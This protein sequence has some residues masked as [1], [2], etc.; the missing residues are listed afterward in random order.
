[1]SLFSFLTFSSLI[2]SPP[3]SSRKSQL[4]NRA[5]PIIGPRYVGSRISRS[6][7]FWGNND[8]GS[9][10]AANGAGQEETSSSEGSSYRE[11]SDGLDG[12]NRLSEVDD[13]VHIK[14]GGSLRSST[15]RA[16]VKTEKARSTKEHHTSLL[17]GGGSSFIESDGWS[18]VKTEDGLNSVSKDNCSSSD[19]DQVSTEVDDEVDEDDEESRSETTENSHDATRR[20]ELRKMMSEEQS[21]VVKSIAEATKADAAKGRAVKQQRKVF[22]SFLNIRIQLQKALVAINSLSAIPSVSTERDSPGT[23][24]FAAAEEVAMRLWMQLNDFRQHRQNPSGSSTQ[25]STG[26]RKRLSSSHRSLSEMMTEMQEMERLAKTQRLST[27]EKWSERLRAV[28]GQGLSKLTNKAR[29]PTMTDVLNDHLANMEH[30]VK[31]TKIPRS[32]APVQA[33]MGIEQST[34]IYDDADFYQLQLKEL[35]NQRMLDSTV[36]ALTPHQGQTPWSVMR[37]AK[38]KRHV[39][40]R[41]SK[42]RKMRYTV[43]EKLQNFMVPEDRGTW[44]KRQTDELFGSLL[45][46][47]MMLDEGEFDDMDADGP[48][49][50]E[51]GLKLFRS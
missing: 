22:D 21:T 47:Q 12:R 46:A 13:L 5:G 49:D 19:D 44:G 10:I 16:D 41:A 27:L 50:I 7:L 3:L 9:L 34:D 26:K 30:L 38:T 36:L 31:R 39:D 37:E 20:D 8:D 18:E 43:Q 6:Q 32:C 17:N 45:G 33:K 24:A 29:E 51:E 42:G 25:S 2:R 48:R 1:M 14:D 15:S 4:R 11:D 28:N 23:E 40:T 35:V